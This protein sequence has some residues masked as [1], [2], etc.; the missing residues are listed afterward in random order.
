M[1][2]GVYIRKLP[3]LAGS[4]P[5]NEVS[6]ERNCEGWRADL[7]GFRRFLISHLAV[8]CGDGIQ[9]QETNCIFI[10]PSIHE[11]TVKAFC[12]YSNKTLSYI[13]KNEEITFHVIPLTLNQFLQ[14]FKKCSYEN[15][16]AN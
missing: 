15:D 14:I 9:G 5:Q 7:I 1:G 16:P 3:A 12:K 2:K 13:V 11:D 4:E 6:I 10:A 8:P